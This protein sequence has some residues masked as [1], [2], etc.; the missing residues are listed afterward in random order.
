M[1][2]RLNRIADV[3]SGF[4]ENSLVSRGFCEVEFTAPISRIEGLRSK[5]QAPSLRAMDRQSGR[6]TLT[7]PSLKGTPT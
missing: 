3:P 5:G 6:F 4:E 2:Q 7:A 1:P